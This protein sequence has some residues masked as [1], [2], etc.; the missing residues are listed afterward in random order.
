MDRRWNNKAN[1]LIGIEM[2]AGEVLFEGVPAVLVR[3]GETMSELVGGG[4]QIFYN[5]TIKRE[6]IKKIQLFK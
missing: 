2:P 4:N 3:V 5:G 6:W 1:V